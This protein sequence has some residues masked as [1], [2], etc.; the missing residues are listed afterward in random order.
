MGL[1]TE[2][3][4]DEF[5]SIAS[6]FLDD[7]LELAEETEVQ[8]VAP[9]EFEYPEEDSKLSEWV[10]DYLADQGSPRAHQYTLNHITFPFVRDMRFAASPVVPPISD[11]NESLQLTSL[12]RQME[13]FAGAATVRPGDLMFFYKSDTQQESLS[14][15]RTPYHNRLEKNRGIV[16]I[17]RALSEA[18][19]DPAGVEHPELEPKS[20]APVSHNY[21]IAGSCS[22]PDCGC[23]FSWMRGD[24]KSSPFDD[25]DIDGRWCPGS[26]LYD[27]GDHRNDNTGYGSLTLSGR[28]W[29]EP[30]VAFRLPAADNS[31]YGNL[32][33][34]SVIWT[35]R[36]DNAMGAGKS[37]TIRHLLPEE[38]VELTNILEVQ[39]ESLSD[40]VEAET[41]ANVEPGEYPGSETV[42]PLIYHDGRPVEKPWL[43]HTN[44]KQ[45]LEDISGVGPK[46]AER[47]RNHGIQSVDELESASDIQLREVD[48]IGQSTVDTI[49]DYLEQEER[50]R[51]RL[52]NNLFL[53]MVQK[54]DRDS[55]FMQFISELAGIEPDEA[56]DRLEYFS[57]EFP[58]GFANDQSDFV[59]TFRDE[60]RT[61]AVLLENKRGYIDSPYALGEL[62]LY[63][64]WVAKVLT[65]FTSPVPDELRL[66]PVLV[67]RGIG[68]WE[69]PVLTDGFE[70]PESQ[71]RQSE[72]DVIVE[73]SVFAEYTIKPEEVQEVT[74]ERIADD[75]RFQD[76]SD[77]FDRAEWNPNFSVLSATDDETAFVVENWLES[78]GSDG[79]DKGLQKFI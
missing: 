4:R 13:I 57:W 41:V 46:T 70:V 71:L 62:M 63:V 5:P 20:D 6:N 15:Y 47:L 58:W 12:G 19:I 18:F 42:L 10:S 68:N 55:P 14:D 49:R 72:I 75:L 23:V 39:S 24:S 79:S 22:N 37:S 25:S 16:G 52:E 34:D 59:C 51:V 38:A 78:Q 29:I 32:E 17:Y 27:N 8:S 66:T 35:G 76:R 69:R 67:S 65:R 36:F 30:I 7:A 3:F 2:N 43:V 11:G 40:V 45:R 50:Y 64:P 54:V 74:G 53:E 1:S 21:R 26:L 33:G 28:I 77:E 48:R 9:G 44:P 56:I 31:V 61:R 73:D 60:G